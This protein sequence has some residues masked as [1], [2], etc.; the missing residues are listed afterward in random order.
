MKNLIAFDMDGT[1]IKGQSW[2]KVNEYYGTE[3]EALEVFNNWLN[4][5]FD[6]LEFM[7]RVISLWQPTPHLSDLKKIL[8]EYELA[9]DARK[10]V[11][12]L[13]RKDY[14]PVIISAGIDIQAEL[15]AE[16]LG[17]PEVYANGFETDEDGYL[18]GKGIKRVELHRKD[19]VLERICDERGIRKEDCVG[20]GDSE[21]DK[22]MF[23]ASGFSISIGSEIEE[24]DVVI[25]DFNDFNLILDYIK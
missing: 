25:P 16:E 19:L 6:Y 17:I 23:K 14:D 8:K 2:A 5:E 13:K 9:P 7:R 11:A 22:R 1:L 3:K 12:E 10:V 21:F 24:V 15:V 4:G 18:T 20:V